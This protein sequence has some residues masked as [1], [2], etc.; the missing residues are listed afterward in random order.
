VT[1]KLPSKGHF[2]AASAAPT[3]GKVWTNQSNFES[4]AK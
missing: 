1:A 4:M 2:F 3:A